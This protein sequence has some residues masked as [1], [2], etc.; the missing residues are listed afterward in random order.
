MWRVRIIPPDNMFTMFNK[1]TGRQPNVFIFRDKKND[2]VNNNI[3]TAYRSRKIISWY[4][5]ITLNVPFNNLFT[6]EK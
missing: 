4:Y 5:R 6:R 2:T 1:K 3:F